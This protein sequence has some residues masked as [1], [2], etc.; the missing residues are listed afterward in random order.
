M[1]SVAQ[2]VFSAKATGGS[3]DHTF[4]Q[5]G[6]PEHLAWGKAELGTPGT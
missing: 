2:S 4:I 1:L 6:T 5:Q 3:E